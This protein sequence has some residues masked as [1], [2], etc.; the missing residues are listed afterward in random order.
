MS[1]LMK[2][3]VLLGPSSRRKHASGVGLANDSHFEGY[4]RPSELKRYAS[5][6]FDES[7]VV[8]ETTERFASGRAPAQE[9]VFTLEA[10]SDIWISRI[11]YLVQ[12]NTA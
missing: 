12:A 10:G 9:T 6:L 4:W 11:I 1:Q 2:V 8:S 7:R 3:S 5:C